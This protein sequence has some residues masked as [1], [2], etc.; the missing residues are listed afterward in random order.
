[1]KLI[2]LVAW[3]ICS[4]MSCFNSSKFQGKNEM[5]PE[6]SKFVRF[7]IE[8]RERFSKK[9][10]EKVKLN[11]KNISSVEISISEPSCLGINIMSFLQDSSGSL[12]PMQFRIKP[13][14]PEK[15]KRLSPGELFS[16]VFEYSLSECYDLSNPGSY[17]LHF[18]YRGNIFGV[19]G[20]KIANDNVLKC[21][22]KIILVTD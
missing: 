14:C 15:L 21:D 7:S 9:E 8:L 19:D 12:L 22:A 10:N 4:C 5:L 13:F 17:E 1:M 18:E 6:K 11:F 20:K 3:T 16:T 2:F